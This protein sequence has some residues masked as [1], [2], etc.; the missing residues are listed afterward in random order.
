[1]RTGAWGWL[2]FVL[3]LACLFML[4]GVLFWV[5][6]GAR[7]GDT[8]A[9][10]HSAYVRGDWQ[11]ASRIAREQLKA[12]P[13]DRDALRLLARSA[14][15]LNDKSAQAL[16]RRLGSEGAEAEDYF[17]LGSALRHE[18]Q[19]GPGMVA[20]E[21]AKAKDPDHAETLNALTELYSSKTFYASAAVV[22]RRLATRPGWE[23]RG[24]WALGR[25]Q[26]REHDAAGAASSLRA[27]LALDPKCETIEASPAT[28]RKHL[29][30]ALLMGQE[31]EQARAT[32]ELQ[33]G[34]DQID[35][36]VAW[37]L[38]R[39]WLQEGNRAEAERAA[40]LAGDFAENDPSIQ[41]PAP[42]VGDAR[43]VS[44]HSNLCRTQLTS[45][46]ANTFAPV[47]STADLP[48]PE[49]PLPDP[50]LP[51]VTHTL[52]R[53]K[54][55]IHIDTNANSGHYSALVEFVLGSGHRGRTA[56]V[57]DAQGLARE[58]R[59]THYAN[60]V[61]WDLTVH[62]PDRPDIGWGLLG[63]PMLEDQVEDCLHCHVT[64]VR[65][66]RLRSKPVGNDR[67]IRCEGCHGPAGNHLKAVALSLPDLAIGQARMS[68][69]AQKNA[70]CA[71][72]HRAPAGAQIESRDYV[73]FQSP[74]L[75][76]SRCFTASNGALDCV[77]C[78]N[79]HKD[80]ETSPAFY[81]KICLEC[82]RAGPTAGQLITCPIEP[83][84]GCVKCHMPSVPEAIPHATYT[85][86]FIRVHRERASGEE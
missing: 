36:E 42:F 33:I 72:C 22:A 7:P 13:N 37:L 17:V 68:G 55:Q 63:K 18:G 57:R 71:D 53:D 21:R 40:N 51:H 45:R 73:R 16:Y 81:D 82:H 34:G 54:D 48:L 1:M 75:V 56:L 28:V 31:P 44:C 59:L 26:I 4:A 85:D 25:L 24:N 11:A 3:G 49:G 23:A 29:A 5:W 84:R 78:H 19:E 6:R 62:H 79:P 61:G 64:D 10:G 52:S 12:A 43:C 38:S 39:A 83:T 2:R 8:L 47:E 27:V 15:R 77:T 67:G 70:M 32:L 58:S 69:H 60:D 66:V 14:A 30:R 46:H 50:R 86:H 35:P 41:E 74:N 9:L 65:S 20:F 80:A 76:K